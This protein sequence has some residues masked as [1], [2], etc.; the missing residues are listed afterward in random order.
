MNLLNVAVVFGASVLS[1]SH[2]PASAP[3]GDDLKSA[4]LTVLSP[5]D[6]QVFQRESRTRGRILI[7]GRAGVTGDA[8]E[9]SLSGKTLE[10]D[11]STGWQKIALEPMTGRFHAELPARAGGWYRFDIRIMKNGKEVAK[12]SIEHVGV[13]EVFVGAGQ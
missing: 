13:G 12:Q 3:A 2:A 9:V 7:G 6:Y 5:Q 11:A 4:D 10:G 8:A 1:Q